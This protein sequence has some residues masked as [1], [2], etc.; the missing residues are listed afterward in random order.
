MKTLLGKARKTYSKGRKPSTY[1]ACR[2]VK[3]QEQTKSFYPQQAV[4]GYT[5]QLDVKYNIKNSN[6]EERKIHGC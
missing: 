4:E 3:R 1:K 6:G 5:K 2:E